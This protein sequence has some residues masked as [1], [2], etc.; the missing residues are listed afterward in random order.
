MRVW[1]FKARAEMIETLEW[2]SDVIRA[3]S[4]EQ[5]IAL[6]DAPRR[7]FNLQHLLDHPMY[8]AARALIRVAEELTVPDWTQSVKV[9]AVNAGTSVSVSFDT[10]GL[11]YSAGSD[12]IIWADWDDWEL[13]EIES[14]DST[15]VVIA[16]VLTSRPDVRLIPTVVGMAF[17]G[18]SADR[19]AGRYIPSSVRISV[20]QTE[21]IAASSY[22]QYRGHDVMTVCP[23]VSDGAFGESVVWP[24]EV[25]DSGLGLQVW[26]QERSIPDESFM[27]RWHE[28]DRAGIRSLREWLHSRYGR[29]KAFWASTWATDFLLAASIG[30]SDTSIQV[31]RYQLFG[32]LPREDFD[33][34]VVIDGVRYYRRV[35][36]VIDG[37]TVEGKA[38]WHL[39]IDSALGVSATEADRISYLRCARFDADRVELLHRAGEGM[40][41]SVPCVEVPVP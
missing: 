33:I 41:V 34:E 27:I 6:R 20:T 16:E 12:A 22:P 17:E 10:A 1:P 2:R 23:V 25:I 15:G 21:N 9:G 14:A 28:F 40:A 32:D 19:P 29:Q 38:T 5:R 11:D 7:D 31:F 24:A 8:A 36:S 3:K 35:T 13:V 4:E 26:L 39:A 37:G 30:A 18:M